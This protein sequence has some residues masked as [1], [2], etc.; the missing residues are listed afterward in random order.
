M[1]KHTP[2]AFPNSYGDKPCFLCSFTVAEFINGRL[3][4]L[5]PLFSTYI[6]DQCSQTLFSYHQKELSL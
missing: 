2:I 4:S 5:S 3:Y 1:I 6:H